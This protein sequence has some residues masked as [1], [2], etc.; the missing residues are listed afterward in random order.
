MTDKRFICSMALLHN[1][2]LNHAV[3]FKRWK[4]ASDQKLTSL[5]AKFV[6]SPTYPFT[7]SL[8][9]MVILLTSHLANSPFAW[10]FCQNVI[11]PICCLGSSL[12]QTCHFINLSFHQRV[13][14][15]ACHFQQLILSDSH[16]TNLSFVQLFILPT[17]HFPNLSFHQI[18]ISQSC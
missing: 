10:L 9:L 3:A 14:S 16:F 18:V 5:C 11:L 15:P 13:I 7:N 12:L 17:C 2:D 1:F 6:I 4:W 8:C